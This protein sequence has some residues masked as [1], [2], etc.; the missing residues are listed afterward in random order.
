[1]GMFQEIS[2]NG[3][4]DTPARTSD[5][6]DLGCHFNW[7]ENERISLDFCLHSEYQDHNGVDEAFPLRFSHSGCC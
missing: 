6:D 7:T 3:E 1:M 5:N 2:R 4:A